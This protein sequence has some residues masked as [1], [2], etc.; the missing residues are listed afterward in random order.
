[1]RQGKKIKLKGR[2]KRTWKDV[3][4]KLKQAHEAIVK[5]V[6]A[7][8]DTHLNEDYKRLCHEMAEVLCLADFPLDEGQP[9]CWAAAIVHAIGWVNFLQDPHHSPH[10]TTTQIADC[11]GVSQS[12]M[13]AKSKIIRDEL[14]LIQMDPDWCTPAM[15]E[16]NPL[17]WMLK[18]NGFIID[19][20]AAPRGAQEEAYRLG[21]IPYIPADRQ[22]T[23]NEI[24]FLPNLP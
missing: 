19:I 22:K 12:T 2:R 1:M 20:R 13:L 15:L 5:M 11:F 4:D 17:V 24:P 10:M 14:D 3:P 16:N 18:V 7:F 8:C 23:D 6:D 9:T 21:L